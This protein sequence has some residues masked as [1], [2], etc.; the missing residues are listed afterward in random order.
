MCAPVATALA[1]AALAA[2][3]L[4]GCGGSSDDGNGPSDRPAPNP[5]DFPPANGR[6]LQEV[7]SVSSGEAPVVSPAARVLRLGENRFAFGVFTIARDQVTNAEVAIYAAPGTGLEGTA[8]GPFTARIESLSTEPAFRAETTSSDPDAAQAIYIT[9]IPLDK[10]GPWTFGAL[11]KEGDGYAG[12]L[13]P[14]PSGVG[15]FDPPDVGDPAPRVHTP[16]ADEVADISEIDTRVPPGDMH[17][18]DL[19][20]VLGRKPVVL[21]FATPQLCQSR[22]CGPVVDVAEQVKREFGDRVAFIHQEVYNDNEINKGVRPQ[23]RAYRLPSEPWLFVIDRGGK[24]S[25]VIEG[26]F[27]VGELQDAVRRVA[28]GP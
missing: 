18:E 4:A 16:T 26:A 1:A 13:L 24:V 15:Q 17:D 11:V 14:T 21:L 23:M 22:V 8:I 7:L 19:A 3:L 5:A 10:P 2:A 27:S 12:S 28:G 20:D 9:Q 6:T 25:T